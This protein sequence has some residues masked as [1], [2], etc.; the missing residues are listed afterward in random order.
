MSENK[1]KS[2][3]SVDKYKK[4]KIF[5]EELL[6]KDNI[7]MRFKYDKSISSKYEPREVRRRLNKDLVNKILRLTN[8]NDFPMYIVLFTTLALQ[9]S[10]Y[11]NKDEGIIGIPVY[12]SSIQSNSMSRN[13][14]LPIKFFIK[15]DSTI[16][17]LLKNMKDLIISAYEYKNYNLDTLLS[18]ANID[19][20]LKV[21]PISISM[22]GLHENQ[23]IDKLKN[24]SNNEISIFINKY[25]NNEIELDFIYNSSI[26]KEETIE[27]FIER[28]INILD[29]ICS[30]T[31]VK[32]SEIDMLSQD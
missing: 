27:L 24:N 15:S 30:N 29:S 4:S 7:E 23:Y 16:K 20:I 31:E 21:I 25:D 19:S 14:V 17:Q 28:Y 3:V 2:K 26:F 6:I 9:I 10:K 22:A 8:N 12:E 13:S 5:W 18:K 11:I 32:I 1:Y